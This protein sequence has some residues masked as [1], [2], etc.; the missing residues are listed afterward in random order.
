MMIEK[1]LK[2]MLPSQWINLLMCGLDGQT[3][4]GYGMTVTLHFPKEKRK[5]L[6]DEILGEKVIEAR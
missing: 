5:E 4:S 2:L 6:L 3:L 1:L